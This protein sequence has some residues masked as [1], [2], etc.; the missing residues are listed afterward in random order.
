MKVNLKG[1]DYK[2]FGVFSKQ[3]GFTVYKVHTYSDTFE[4]TNLDYRGNVHST[5]IESIN[6][7]V[8]KE[9]NNI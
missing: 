9:I 2:G 1:W 5:M 3:V 6:K 7:R 8:I 4:T